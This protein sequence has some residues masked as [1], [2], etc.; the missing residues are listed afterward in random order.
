MI[1]REF[2]VRGVV[3]RYPGTGG[4]YFVDVGKKH[5]GMLRA[6]PKETK[7]GWGYVPV[8]A[9]LGKSEW[10]TTLFPTKA[11]SYLLAIKAKVRTAE[12]VGAG[13]T[14]TAHIRLV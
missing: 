14:V 8:R 9:T 4:W 7:V 13:D 12:G 10:R 1:N 2:R 11:G 6:R 3:K 5:A